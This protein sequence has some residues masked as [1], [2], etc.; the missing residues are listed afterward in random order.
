[1]DR[2]QGGPVRRCRPVALRPIRGD[3]AGGTE[4][5]RPGLRRTIGIAKG[6]VEYFSASGVIMRKKDKHLFAL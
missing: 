5:A 3:P 1:M 2:A 4:T 6:N